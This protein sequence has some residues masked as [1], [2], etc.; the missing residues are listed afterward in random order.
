[1]AAA[2]NIIRLGTQA[3]FGLARMSD[4]LTIAVS[5]AVTGAV[6]Q[7]RAERAEAMV[8]TRSL[9]LGIPPE[10]YKSIA[11]DGG[12]QDLVEEYLAKSGPAP[13]RGM[14]AKVRDWIGLDEDPFDPLAVWG[15]WRERSSII[16]YQTL[17][18]LGYRLGPFAGFLQTRLNQISY[19]SR[20][21]E[22][23]HGIGFVIRRK[24]RQTT[25]DDRAEEIKQALLNSGLS[26][27]VD[28]ETGDRRDT[29]P[30]LMRKIIRDS[31]RFDQINIERRR[32]V[33]GELIEWRALDARTIRRVGPEYLGKTERG[34]P[35]RFVQVMHGQ[36][37]AEFSARDLTFFVRN[38]RTSIRSWGY[39]ESELEM[40]VNTVTALLNGFTYNANFF[41]QGTTAKGMLSLS[42]LVPPRG[43][44]HFKRLWYSM[45][46]G[47]D[48]AWRTPILN[49]PDEKAK[50]EWI[51]LQKSNLDMEWSQ[52]MEWCLKV[53]CSVWQI[54]PEEIGFQFGNQGQSSSLNEGNVKY[55]V[56]ASKDRGLF[57][58]L[59]Q[60]ARMVTEEIV[61]YIDPE[62][63]FT[64][65]GHDQDSEETEVKRRKEEASTYKTVDEI[66]AECDLDEMPDRKGAVVLNPVWLQNAQAID[67]QQGGQEQGPPDGGGAFSDLFPDEDDEGEGGDGN[68]QLAPGPPGGLQKSLT[69]SRRRS[70]RVVRYEII[71]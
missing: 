62:Y 66:R 12:E 49:M 2:A 35:V 36:I 25:D 43:L 4:R 3:A 17:E 32:N 63:E 65:A 15:G 14:G 67:A 11:D 68:P 28:E 59:N 61:E 30:V 22:D 40:M 38:P 44:R 19:H 37:M 6:A 16:S 31:L 70:P 48:N 13:A 33:K 69:R 18:A 39:G 1:V 5:G 10:L 46:T 8:A 34:E 51:D 56:D 58:L 26:D 41:S 45:V 47:T 29:L 55:K 9:A 71:A 27:P 60:I 42:G 21:Q 54:A 7:A 20:P 64:F 53:A 23:K 57:P 24:D 52:F 50:A